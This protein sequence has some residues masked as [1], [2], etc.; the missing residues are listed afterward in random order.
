MTNILPIKY[1]LDVICSCWKNAEL[2][3]QYNIKNFHPGAG[4]VFI[5]ELFHGCLKK[6][7]DSANKNKLIE[8]AF[9][10]D[11]KSAFP[12]IDRKKNNTQQ[13]ANGLI[14]EVKLHNQ[15]T[16]T[17]TGGD[18][19]FVIAR[20]L[21]SLENPFSNE[22][23]LIFSKDYQRG[24]L[25]QAKL[26]N[27][28]GKWDG[29]TPTQEEI[30]PQH[31]DYLALLLYQYSDENR[32]NLEQFRWQLGKGY[33][34]PDL[35]DWFKDDYFPNPLNSSKIISDLG[36]AKIGTGDPQKIRN[37]ICPPENRTLSIHIHWPGGDPPIS[38]VRIRT[39]QDEKHEAKRV[40][41]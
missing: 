2:S 24:I 1:T 3:L 20:P 28:K 34:F 10:H 27:D 14:A 22:T 31:L 9:I 17:R 11:L 7:L 33:A 35:K 23:D 19:G 5:T 32:Y 12:Y 29:F 8:N 30:L 21:F 26:K 18:L 13:C 4:E 36:D 16:E 6:S 41:W 15:T 25:T 40:T 37:V 38:R 39:R